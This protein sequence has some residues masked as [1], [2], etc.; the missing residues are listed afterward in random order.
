VRANE[1]SLLV[2]CAY[3]EHDKADVE[4]GVLFTIAFK[5]EKT[6]WL[7]TGWEWSQPL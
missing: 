5:Q 6:D 1:D 4:N 3:K 2:D 7:I